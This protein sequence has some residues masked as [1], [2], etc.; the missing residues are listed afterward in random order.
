MNNKKLNTEKFQL[1]LLIQKQTGTKLLY[2]TDYQMAPILNEVLKFLVL[3]MFLHLD[4]T[5]NQRNIP[6]ANLLHLLV[7]DH[8]G[9]LM[10]SEV[11]IAEEADG[12]RD[13]ESADTTMFDVQ[14]P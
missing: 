11:P 7:Q 5:N 9:P 10:F 8:Q 6:L 12:V 4:C 14:T 2:I 13:K 3:F 1:I